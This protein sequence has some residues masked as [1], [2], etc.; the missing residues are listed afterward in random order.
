MNRR[1]QTQETRGRWTTHDSM[2][3]TTTLPRPSLDPWTEN[4]TVAIDARMAQSDGYANQTRDPNS[5]T[6]TWTKI[7][8]CYIQHTCWHWHQQLAEQPKLQRKRVQ[9]SLE[10]YGLQ[11][12][13]VLVCLK[14]SLYSSFAV[15]AFYRG[16]HAS[17]S[18]ATWLCFWFTLATLLL[19]NSIYSPLKF[20]S[21]WFPIWEKSL[22]L[23]AFG[24]GIYRI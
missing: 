16:Q 3:S 14:R 2:N 1:R 18:L 23:D 6:T 21:L 12:R 9:V 4:G 17:R 10:D 19:F 13:S 22:I 7:T 5:A 8:R 15:Q 20:S 24:L 11:A